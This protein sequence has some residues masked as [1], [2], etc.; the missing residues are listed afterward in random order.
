V[1]IGELGARTGASARMLRYYEEQGLLKPRRTEGGFRIYAEEDV[2]AVRRIRC[3]LAAALPIEV[4]AMVL[5]CTGERE[6]E[7]PQKTQ[8]CRPLMEVLEG[9]LDT[10]NSKID[11]LLTSREALQG[12]LADVREVLARQPERVCAR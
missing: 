7:I 11:E 9:E 10:L 5:A 8:L 6:I 1:Q 3:L 2:A 12:V 4:I